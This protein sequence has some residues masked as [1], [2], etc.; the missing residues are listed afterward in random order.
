MRPRRKSPAQ[1][2]RAKTRADIKTYLREPVLEQALASEQESAATKAVVVRTLANLVA[3]LP[4]FIL[5]TTKNMRLL[6]AAIPDVH[7][8][9]QSATARL[10]APV[11]WKKNP[12]IKRVVFSLLVL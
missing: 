3:T 7:A 10:D 5:D 6:E 4:D 8:R 1:G 2:A 12:S 11:A 9:Y